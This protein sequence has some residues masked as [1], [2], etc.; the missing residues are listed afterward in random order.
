MC[1]LQ[2]N[3]R[4]RPPCLPLTEQHP[5][6]T[7]GTLASLRVL[8]PDRYLAVLYAPQEARADLATLYRFDAEIASIR[9][10]IREPMAGEIRLKWWADALQAGA[11]TGQPLA[12]EMLSVVTRHRLPLSAF[13]RYFEARLFDLYDDPMPDRVTFEAYCGETSGTM[14]QLA[15]IILDAQAASRA[16]E[17]S[18]HGGCAEA[19][20]RV[21][22]SL[23]RQRARGQC[24]VPLEMLAAVGLDRESFLSDEGDAGARAVAMMVALGNEH[25]A[26]FAK[27]T[28]ALPRSLRPAFLP[29]AMS[30]LR[31]QT[32]ARMGGRVLV[33][34]PSLSPIRQNWH[35]WRLA[36]AGNWGR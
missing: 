25:H 8:E 35:M 2:R 5:A 27:V 9:D 14:T 19:T 1:S 31:L 18:G 10:R 16:G 36:V 33:E 13:E 24:Y 34:K 3:G 4:W 20:A 29:A 6:E 12:D 30:R 15:C 26:L 17:A 11:T 22:W 7:E 32:A 28:D 23:A 21:L